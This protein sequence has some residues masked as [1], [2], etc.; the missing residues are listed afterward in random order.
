[1][2]VF[3]CR[4]LMINQCIQAY[5]YLIKLFLW[6]VTKAKVP[7][8]LTSLA[9]ELFH[10]TPFWMRT[11]LVIICTVSGHSAWRTFQEQKQ[12]S[13]DTIKSN[14]NDEV[15][16]VMMVMIVTVHVKRNIHTMNNNNSSHSSL[17]PP[18]QEEQH[19]QQQRQQTQQQKQE[20][21]ATNE[22]ILQLCYRDG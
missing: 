13:K 20:R 1:M 9:A 5:G 2:A 19:L 17:Q 10:S 6:N 16:M 8:L 21:L 22:A 3:S 4:Q 11:T 12:P 15:I 7:S 14:D 18:G